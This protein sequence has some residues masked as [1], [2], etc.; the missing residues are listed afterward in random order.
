MRNVIICTLALLGLSLSACAPDLHMQQPIAFGLIQSG[1]APT[2]VQEL[3]SAL[4]IH[5]KEL[6]P[7]LETVKVEEKRNPYMNFGDLSWGVMAKAIGDAF[8]ANDRMKLA[9]DK[10]NTAFAALMQ[11][12]SRRETAE[13]GMA[14]VKE[15]KIYSFLVSQMLR[16]MDA[17]H[18]S[19]PFQEAIL[20]QLNSENE[21]S[22]NKT[23]EQI[24]KSMKRITDTR[25]AF[26]KTTH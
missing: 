11:D 9:L 24:G 3:S 10:A 19:L 22:F 26:A 23:A 13:S 6:V 5:D 14:L 8:R 17:Y 12:S 1:N 18:R 15:M 20:T 2:A 7:A 21:D 25:N 4:S 16:D